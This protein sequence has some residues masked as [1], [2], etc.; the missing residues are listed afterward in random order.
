MIV[1]SLFIKLIKLPC[2][3]VLM[4]NFGYIGPSRSRIV[5]SYY[6]SPSRTPSKIARDK[7][8]A[9]KFTPNNARNGDTSQ[10]GLDP[11]VPDWD[12]S[13]YQYSRMSDFGFKKNTRKAESQI[14][15][16]IDSQGFRMIDQ[17][18]YKGINYPLFCH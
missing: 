18:C 4:S 12:S 13:Q 11:Y 9:F 1:V 5:N 14:R 15:H 17:I 6:F 16:D 2:H 8:Q 7:S 3:V 10:V